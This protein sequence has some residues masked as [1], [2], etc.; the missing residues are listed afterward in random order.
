MSVESTL[1]ADLVKKLYEA[2]DILDKLP[3]RN[4]EL[5]AVEDNIN[6]ALNILEDE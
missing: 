1:R 3:V 2:L 5:I 4:D 6:Q